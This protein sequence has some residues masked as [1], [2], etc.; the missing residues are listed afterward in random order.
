MAELTR[1]D[2]DR[3]EADRQAKRAELVDRLTLVLAREFS[4]AEIKFIWNWP[5]NSILIE[6]FER[7]RT[8]TRK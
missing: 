4:L 2:I 6:S 3:M 1:Q 7:A 8:E 5:N